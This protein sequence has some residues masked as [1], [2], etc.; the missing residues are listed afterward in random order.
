VR[1]PGIVLAIARRDPL[2]LPRV[3]P[4]HLAPNRF[5]SRLIQADCA[6]ASRAMRRRSLPEV[7]FDGA[8]QV[9]TTSLFDDFAVR[10][11]NAL[12]AQFIAQIDSNVLDSHP[13]LAPVMVAGSPLHLIESVSRV[14]AVQVSQPSHLFIYSRCRPT[15]TQSRTRV[16]RHLRA[17]HGG[18]TNPRISLRS[19]GPARR[20]HTGEE[21]GASNARSQPRRGVF[22]R[23]ILTLAG[24]CRYRSVSGRLM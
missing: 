18:P 12:P 1:I 8:N 11:E 24:S 16:V 4:D 3:G 21:L 13:C 9:P 6:P 17:A 10:I 14:T 7:L 5:S 15:G 20:G 2:Q 19:K 23:A 22:D